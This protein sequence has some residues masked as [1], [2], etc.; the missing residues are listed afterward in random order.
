[1]P[2]VMAVFPFSN[3]ANGRSS[4]GNASTGFSA[5]SAVCGS[6]PDMLLGMLTSA[7]GVSSA[8]S[9]NFA[10]VLAGL[11]A[12]LDRG[13]AGRKD[14]V[15][16]DD[17]VM[18]SYEQAL[19]GR[20]RYRVAGEE[21][22]SKTV[23]AGVESEGVGIRSA[24]NSKGRISKAGV[25]VPEEESEKLKAV[26]REK[27]VAERKAASITIRLSGEECAQVHARAAEAGMT[28]SAYLRSCVFEAE[29]LR[30][31]VKKALAELRSEGRGTAVAT[32]PSEGWRAR[33]FARWASSRG[34]AR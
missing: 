15:L 18:L 6:T 25:A 21:A 33:L 11:A 26:A 5:N 34:G 32:K 27:R 14:D 29:S 7:D 3:S 13:D 4:F 2:G 23:K 17:V 10:S 31:Q 9:M 8:K 16:A 1:V 24:G 19:R 20:G 22:V 28:M 12:K 30:A